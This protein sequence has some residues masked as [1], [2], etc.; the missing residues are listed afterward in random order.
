MANGEGR[1]QV[2]NRELLD[3]LEL[4]AT[5]GGLSVDQVIEKAILNE[6]LIE[7]Q[8]RHGRRWQ[9]RDERDRTADVD[10]A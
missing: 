9:I 4:T 8:V 6:A 5:R 3:I 10:F 2:L 7:E 1:F